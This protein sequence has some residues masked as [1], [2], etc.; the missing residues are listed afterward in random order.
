[1]RLVLSLMK[2]EA[3]EKT[4]E[5]ITQLF[6]EDPEYYPESMINVYL[7]TIFICEDYKTCELILNKPSAMP[8]S[9]VQDY[10]LAL[11]ILQHKYEAA[12]AL[13]DSIQSIGSQRLS[14]KFDSLCGIYQNALT[15][16]H[17]YPG[18]A[19]AL[20]TVIPGTGHAYSGEMQI[21]IRSFMI[22]GLYAWQSYRAFRI[23]GAKNVYAWGFGALASGFY[24]AG[25]Y[26]SYASA[27]R[28]NLY[29]EKQIRNEVLD[30]I[31]H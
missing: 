21:G 9:S 28:S 7:Q 12:K 22:I 26:G 2:S 11:Y 30:I 13:K 27:K 25:I 29:N 15:I 5:R 20:S 24:T 23:K 4:H 1:M 19:A 18:L 10:R 14:T 17:K 31:L 16:D 8:D 6:G 3:Y